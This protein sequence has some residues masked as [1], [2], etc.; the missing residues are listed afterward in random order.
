[1]GYLFDTFAFESGSRMTGVWK[2]KPLER[3]GELFALASL[4]ELGRDQHDVLESDF[5][6]AHMPFHF[7]GFHGV[8]PDGHP[9][10]VMLQVAPASAGLLGVDPYWPMLD[11]LDRAWHYNREAT[12]LVNDFLS[13]PGLLRVYARAGVAASAVKEWDVGD[14]MLG[15]LAEC[16]GVTLH[17]IALGRVSQCAFP[18]LDHECE[19]DVFDDVFAR[20]GSGHLLLEGDG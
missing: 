1:M 20:W 9:W 4:V 5:L 19:H 2:A 16:C 18:D 8:G 13:R 7:G 11:G 17:Q 3:E 14:L 12:V 10:A 6:G 15:L